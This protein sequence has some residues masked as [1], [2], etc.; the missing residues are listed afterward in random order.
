[1]TRLGQQLSALNANL[2]NKLQDKF[3]ENFKWELRSIR[4]HSALSGRVKSSRPRDGE[5]RSDGEGSVSAV[6]G[7][8][9]SGLGTML[10][11][12]SQLN[13]S[14]HELVQQTKI[15]DRQIELLQKQ[16]TLMEKRQRA[17]DLQ[18]KED[19]HVPQPNNSEKNFKD[20]GAGSQ[21][22]QTR[23]AH[24]VD[25]RKQPQNEIQE[26]KTEFQAIHAALDKAMEPFPARGR[27]SIKSRNGNAQELQSRAHTVH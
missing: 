11:S 25:G 18:E 7:L 27:A 16:I 1:L 17:Q 26:H 22:K 24:D 21:E 10:T 5:A 3:Q 12:L 13:L 6:S 23:A 15:A 8:S 9:A 14:E 19:V 2:Q 4:S 20:F